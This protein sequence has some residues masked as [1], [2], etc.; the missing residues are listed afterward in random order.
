MGLDGCQKYFNMLNW[1][2]KILTRALEWNLNTYTNKAAVD[3]L[4]SY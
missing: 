1:E 4:W 3:L 2:H